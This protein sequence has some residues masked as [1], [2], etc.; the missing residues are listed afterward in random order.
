MVVFHVSAHV[1]CADDL[2]S[3]SCKVRVHEISIGLSLIL[4]IY[5]L[6]V[7][8]VSLGLNFMQCS[9]SFFSKYLCFIR[10]KSLKEVG[11]ASLKVLHLSV[12]G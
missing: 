10:L 1:D 6:V 5:R 8:D 11:K 3:D 9:S 2:S 4:R 7:V 12:E